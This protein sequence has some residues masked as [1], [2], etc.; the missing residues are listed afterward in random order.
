MPTHEN[1]HDKEA[2]AFG[3]GPLVVWIE[4][5][6]HGV[7]MPQPGHLLGRPKGKRQHGMLSFSLRRAKRQHGMLSFSGVLGGRLRITAEGLLHNKQ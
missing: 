4:M 3:G 1:A 5:C 2:A 6:W 7:G